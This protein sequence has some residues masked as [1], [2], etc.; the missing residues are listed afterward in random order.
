MSFLF[1]VRG[2]STKKI[3]TLQGMKKE[4]ATQNETTLL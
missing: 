3:Q 1:V 4:E 2:S